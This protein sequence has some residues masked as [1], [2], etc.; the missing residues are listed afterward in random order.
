VVTLP[1]RRNAHHSQL[2]NT[3]YCRTM[4]ATRFG[5][6]VA[7]VVATIDVPKSHHGEIHKQHRGDDRPIQRRQVH[8][9]DP[10]VPQ[11]GMVSN[12]A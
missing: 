1:D 6:S 3:P 2:S 8:G 10:G 4:P 12:P 5:A 9:F 11:A 7:K